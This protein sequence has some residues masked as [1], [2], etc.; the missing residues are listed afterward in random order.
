MISLPRVYQVQTRLHLRILIY[1][2]LSPYLMGGEN[3]WDYIGL[4][5]GGAEV[6]GVR[7]HSNH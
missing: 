7:E 5:A 1:A 6:L 2:T 4:S 3:I